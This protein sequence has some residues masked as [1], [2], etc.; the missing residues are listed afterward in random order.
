MKVGFIG[1]GRM[2]QAMARRLIEAGPRDE[3]GQRHG[4]LFGIA[5]AGS[6]D[7]YTRP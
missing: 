2:G 1:T 7:D 6:T 4:I 5:A 3:A